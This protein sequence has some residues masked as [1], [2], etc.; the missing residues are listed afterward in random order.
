MP[1]TCSGPRSQVL[2]RTPTSVLGALAHARA[3]ASHAAHVL[4]NE[5]EIEGVARPTLAADILSLP[6]GCSRTNTIGRRARRML[7]DASSAPAI[8]TCPCLCRCPESLSRH[9]RRF[10]VAVVRRPRCGWTACSSDCPIADDSAH[11]AARLLGVGR[12]PKRT[13]CSAISTR[14]L[15]PM[16]G[17]TSLP[18]AMQVSSRR[19]AGSSRCSHA[20]CRRPLRCSSSCLLPMSSRS[21]VT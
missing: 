12:S 8:N 4:L 16:R 20:P 3:G 7:R 19:C 2:R 13:C 6:A 21:P 15:Q 10:V 11:R 18:K 9:Q 1:A 5:A 17:P 14:R